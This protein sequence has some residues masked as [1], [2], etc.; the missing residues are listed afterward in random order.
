MI[1]HFIVEHG[2][3]IG[4]NEILDTETHQWRWG[5]STKL[6]RVFDWYGEEPEF[7]SNKDY[8]C[9]VM[10]QTYKYHWHLQSCSKDHYYI[11]EMKLV[12]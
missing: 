10:W 8:H 2:A 4:L 6:C 7:Q 1:F 9:G 12:S 3:W 11:C 5:Y